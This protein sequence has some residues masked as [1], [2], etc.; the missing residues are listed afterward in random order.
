MT[1]HFFP[2]TQRF[3][4]TAERTWSGLTKADA[5]LLLLGFNLGRAKIAELL[6]LSTALGYFCGRPLTIS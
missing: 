3:E 6:A 2:L 4:I 1:I 5:K